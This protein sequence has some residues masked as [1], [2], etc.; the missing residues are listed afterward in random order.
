MQATS[1]HTGKGDSERIHVSDAVVRLDRQEYQDFARTA[2]AEGAELVNAAVAGLRG[3]F[4]AGPEAREVARLKTL[5]AQVE[6]DA[7]ANARQT[8][9]KQAAIREEWAAGSPAFDL[10]PG[11]DRLESEKDYLLARAEALKGKLAAA[12]AAALKAWRLALGQLVGDLEEQVTD[13]RM[14]ESEGAAR[15]AT[16]LTA[17]L[18]NRH[19][20]SAMMAALRPMRQVL[21][22][23][24]P[25]ADMAGLYDTPRLSPELAV[26]EAP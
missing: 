1:I 3:Q 16:E 11:L 24:R 25:P 5:L 14:A 17:F 13:R 23:W 21:T 20:Y 9:E 18:H 10:K 7:A 6:A 8:A 12:E 22:D 26:P 2:N 19:V 4:A 15:V